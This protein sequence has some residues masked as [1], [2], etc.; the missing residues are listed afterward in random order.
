MFE[1]PGDKVIMKRDKTFILVNLTRWMGKQIIVLNCTNALLL[2]TVL[3]S[4]GRSNKILQTGWLLSN[5]NVFL[6]V[7]VA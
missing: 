5:R 6:T 7:L 1:A 3:V 2:V 4:S